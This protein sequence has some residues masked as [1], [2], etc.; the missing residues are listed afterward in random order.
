MSIKIKALIL[1]LIL[2]PLILVIIWFR[3]GLIMGGGEEGLPFYNITKSVQLSGIWQERATGSLNLGLL[4]W[5]ALLYP[6]EIIHNTLHIP[7]FIFQAVTFW[8]LLMAGMLSTFF[9][10]QSILEKRESSSEIGLIASIFYLLNPFSISQI[11]GRSITAQYF[12]FALLPL[13]ILLF[14]LAL[15]KRNIIFIFLLTF[16][17]LVF[18]PAFLFVTFLMVYWMIILLVFIYWVSRSD[19]KKK[20]YFFGMFLLFLSLILWLA[21]HLWWLQTYIPLGNSISDR[22]TSPEGNL[23][24]L[25]GV[26]RNFTLDLVA[27]LLQKSYFSQG[28]YYGDLYSTVYFQVLT[29]IPLVFLAIGI[30][31]YFK[32]KLKGLGF[33]L[34]LLA[35]GLF[36]SLGGNFPLGW[37]FIWIFK[38]LIL[39]QPFRNPYEKFGLV[40]TLG[41][42]V[43]FAVGLV[44]SIDKIKKWGILLVLILV[45]GILVWPIWT[46]R[47][48]AGPDKKI[49]IAVPNYYQKLSNFLDQNSS[50]YRVFVTPIWNGDGSSYLWGDRFFSGS[51]PMMYLINQPTLTNTS[52]DKNYFDFMSAIRRNL[53]KTDVSAALA[54]LRAKYVV[55]RKDAIQISDND[56]EHIKFLT[57]EIHPPSDPNKINRSTCQNLTAKAEP[58]DTVK[59]TCQIPKNEQNWQGIRYLDFEIKTDSPAALEVAIIDNKNIRER[60]DGKLTPDYQTKNNSSFVTFPLNVPT[61]YNYTN[62]IDLSNIVRVEMVAYHRDPGQA[63]PQSI[64]LKSIRLDEGQEIKSNEFRLVKSFGKLDVYEPTNFI[65]PPEFGNLT[66]LY[67][68]NDF[69]QLFQE[70]NQKRSLVSKEGFLMINQNDKKDLSQLSQK[71]GLNITGKQKISETKYWFKAD[72]PSSGYIILSKTFNPNWKIIPAAKEEL[73]G[74]FSNDIKLLRKIAISEDRHFVV[75]G[76]ANLWK[77]DGENKEYAILFIPQ[78]VADISARVSMAGIIILLGLTGIWSLRN[79]KTLTRRN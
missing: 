60:W 62:P 75:N 34:I 50:E 16:A 40:Y 72:S 53:D 4:P 18:A 11:W 39:L 17:S 58:S 13:S 64:N 55:N 19:Q 26:S 2:I 48:F 77:I 7:N 3:N 23:N 44:Y 51:D 47:I 22:L 54:L 21:A 45:C 41:Y 8:V 36:V 56:K 59:L 78:I 12:S 31:K 65:S 61:E 66:Q 15:K 49:G 5:L 52:A 30:F 35:L 57:K 79:F 20:D 71:S 43:F 1:L 76:Y 29:F 10:I 32:L 68:V 67:Q 25:L 46:G 38:N 74:S 42:S 6:I 73:D 14:W 27:R 63:N 69:E 24:S 37:L 9:L 33:F 28:G 70:V